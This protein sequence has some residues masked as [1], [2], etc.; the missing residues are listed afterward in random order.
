V[1]AFGLIASFIGGLI[2]RQSWIPKSSLFRTLSWVICILLILVH[3]PG[4]IAGRVVAVK[5]V[6]FFFNATTCFSDLGDSPN[7]ENENVI[8]VNAPCQ[9]GF[10]LAPSY[11]AYHRQTLPKTMRTLVP[12]CT[13]F[14]VKRTDD[15]TL[16]IQSRAPDMFS[17]DNA[18]PVHFAYLFRTFNLLLGEPKCK[19]GDRYDMGGLTVDVLELDA[20]DLPSRVAFRFD[21]SLDSPDFHW[22]R[23]DWRTFSY[24]PFE[25]PGIGQSITLPGPRYVTLAEALRQTLGMS[26]GKK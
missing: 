19:K 6:P 15:K 8:V 5:T 10:M 13:G 25:V 11:K 7:M 1:G 4:A 26:R 21:T 14:E 9:L 16:V 18:G 23:F 2:T 17:W 12:G 3:V 24:Q 22:L 20:S